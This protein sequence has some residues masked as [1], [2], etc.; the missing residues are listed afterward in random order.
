LKFAA[1]FLTSTLLLIA[2]SVGSFGR[3]IFDDYARF[4]RDWP[5]LPNS[6]MHWE[7][8]ANIRGLVALLMSG[9]SRLTTVF[10]GIASLIL[11]LLGAWFWQIA[12]NTLSLQRM[13]FSAS[14]LIAL[15]VSY[16]LSPHDLT[17][18]LIP[19]STLVE[20][21]L[22]QGRYKKWL[23]LG[24]AGFIFFPPI[25]IAVLYAKYY[26]LMMIPILVVL[27]LLVSTLVQSSKHATSEESIS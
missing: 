7:A 14:I 6:G 10:A 3:Q 26:V 15:L 21:G 5:D 27:T 1:G 22:E 20:L 11:L 18:L 17:L 16:H 12:G 19:S 4:L 2:I 24:L 23:S 13:A 8:M 9:D 25:H